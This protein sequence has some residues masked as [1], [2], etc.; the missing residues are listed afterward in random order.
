M[1]DKWNDLGEN[2]DLFDQAVDLVTG[3]HNPFPTEHTVENTDTGE[4]KTVYIGSGQSVGE[5]IEKGQFKK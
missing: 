3:G 5:G 1:S 2:K 4:E